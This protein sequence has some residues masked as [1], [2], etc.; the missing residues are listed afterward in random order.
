[1]PKYM[2]LIIRS[3]FRVAGNKAQINAIVRIEPLC[4]VSTE[5]EAASHW[6]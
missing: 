2:F 1:M 3:N 6:V 4:D 5:L